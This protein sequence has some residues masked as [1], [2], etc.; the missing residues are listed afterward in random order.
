[1]AAGAYAV[2]LRRARL[3]D[4]G[5]LAEMSRDLIETGLAWR[6]TPRRMAALIRERETMALVACE[7]DTQRIVGFA[8]MHFG[9]D[10]AHLTLLAVKA[11]QQRNGIGRGLIEWLIKSA[12]VAGMQSI[13][14]ELRADNAAASA[15]YERLGFEETKRTPAYYDGRIPARHMTLGLSAPSG[16][17]PSSLRAVVELGGEAATTFHEP[18]QDAIAHLHALGHQLVARVV[19][20]RDAAAHRFLHHY[21]MMS[22]TQMRSN[23]APA[24]RWMRR[25]VSASAA[26][27]SQTMRLRSA[28]STLRFHVAW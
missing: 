9:D 10:T 28:E 25:M 27:Y 8:I 23:C 5:V 4:A 6:Y 26:S 16:E 1:M 18:L 19:V 12:R 22:P 13:D 17:P 21:S 3:Q 20:A 7:G 2:T 15:F 11:R 14:V 24:S